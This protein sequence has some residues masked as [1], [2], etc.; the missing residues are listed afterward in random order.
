MLGISAPFIKRHTKYVQRRDNHK[1]K[2]QNYCRQHAYSNKNTSCFALFHIY[3]S[4]P[5]KFVVSKRPAV[6]KAFQRR[7]P[8]ERH[9]SY[10]YSGIASLNLSLASSTDACQSATATS[11]LTTESTVA[12]KLSA[13]DTPST[14]SVVANPPITAVAPSS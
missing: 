9:L 1:Y 3:T 14:G 4:N 11:P 13:I 2:K 7:K 6:K 8:S 10:A 12:N 5:S